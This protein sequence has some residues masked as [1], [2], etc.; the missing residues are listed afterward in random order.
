MFEVRLQDLVKEHIDALISERRVEQRN[1]EFKEALPGNSDRDRYEFLADISSFSNTVG[2]YLLYGVTAERDADGKTTGA[3]DAA[4]GL[5]GFNSDGGTLRLE[6]MIRD[7]VAPR[8]PGVTFRVIDGYET[9]PVLAVHVPRSFGGPH[10]LTTQNHSRFF[11][12]GTAGRYQLDVHQLRDSFAA[13]EADGRRLDDFRSSRLARI[14]AGETPVAL[15]PGPKLVLHAVPRSALRRNAA[16]ALDAAIEGSLGPPPLLK[17]LHFDQWNHKRN[18]DGYLTSAVNRDVREGSYT[19]LFRSGAVELVST[20]TLTRHNQRIPGVVMER[21]V[22]ERLAALAALYQKIGVDPPISVMISLLGVKG[23][24]MIVNQSA[25]FDDDQSAIEHDDLIVPDV[26]I[27]TFAASIGSQLRGA[28]DIIWQACD[29]SR[30]P[31]YDDSG[32]WRI[33][34]RR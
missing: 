14:I 6:Q 27:V 25:F 15:A 16:I 26:E 18:F 31:N 32:E 17:P 22:I 2:G 28:F 4:V 20:W 11:A 5:S 30:S 23:F 24:M 12:R 9:G 7:G 10:M 19:Q 8:I 34:A 21:E 3:P 13:S 29:W 33:P 1:L